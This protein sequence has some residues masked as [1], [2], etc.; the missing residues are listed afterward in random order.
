MRGLP[1]GALSFITVHGLEKFHGAGRQPPS[2]RHS[3]FT[4]RYYASEDVDAA[5]FDIKYAP[6]GYCLY[7]TLRRLSADIFAART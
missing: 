4:L 7:A 5:Q 1:A 3:I 6:E 2:R